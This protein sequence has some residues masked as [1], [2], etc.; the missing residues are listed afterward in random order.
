MNRANAA[1]SALLLGTIFGTLSYYGPWTDVHGRIRFFSDLI[2]NPIV[3]WFGNVGAAVF[4]ATFGILL[5]VLA[6][7]GNMRTAD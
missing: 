3:G 4:F 1:V 7:S 6:V 5:A 2:I